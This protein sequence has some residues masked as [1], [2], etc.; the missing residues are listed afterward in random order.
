MLGEDDCG[1]K[2]GGIH[3]YMTRP[4][5]VPH[6]LCSRR[7]QPDGETPICNAQDEI[8]RTGL[9]KMHTSW[10][11]QRLVCAS[12]CR[13]WQVLTDATHKVYASRSEA[14]QL[15]FN[16]Q[17]SQSLFASRLSIRRLKGQRERRGP[18]QER[19]RCVAVLY[20]RVKWVCSASAGR[21]STHACCLACSVPRAC[22]VCCHVLCVS[23]PLY[24][25]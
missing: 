16:M 5:F 12:L 25:L 20:A 13:P 3:T 1:K 15:D 7:V 18:A 22:S 10:Y 11:V 19:R 8:R 21:V 23:S 6:S 14:G 2:M 4:T 24:G 9:G 17:A